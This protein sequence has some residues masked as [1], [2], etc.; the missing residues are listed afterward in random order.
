MRIEANIYHYIRIVIFMLFMTN[1][2]HLNE[3]TITIC[4]FVWPA[5]TVIMLWILD[6]LISS[7]FW[8]KHKLQ[9]SFVF[10]KSVCNSCIFRSFTCL[11]EH[12]NKYRLKRCSWLIVFLNYFHSVKSAKMTF[13]QNMLLA[14]LYTINTAVDVAVFN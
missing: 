13:S 1:I 14:E 3:A 8:E 2:L 12:F 11:Y 9:M 6:T 4:V 5:L 7:I 10:R